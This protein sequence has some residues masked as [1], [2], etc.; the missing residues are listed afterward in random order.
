[1]KLIEYHDH[2]YDEGEYTA[3][4]VLFYDLD[5]NRRMITTIDADALCEPAMFPVCKAFD[6]EQLGKDK[7]LAVEYPNEIVI[8]LV[9]TAIRDAA[10]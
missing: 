10:R 8:G 3:W 2:L 9:K 1:M 7:L 5:R 6:V 4:T